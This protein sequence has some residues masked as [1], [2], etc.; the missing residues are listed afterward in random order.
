MEALKNLVSIGIGSI[1]KIISFTLATILIVLGL[2]TLTILGERNVLAQK[3]ETKKENIRTKEAEIA[4]KS[5]EISFMKA[6]MARDKLDA[7]AKD[8]EYNRTMA[9][10]P[11]Y[12]TSI[13]YVPTGDKCADL[14]GIINEARSNKKAQG[15]SL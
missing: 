7:K 5:K 14:N 15:E 4:L 2:Y 9:A 3:V 8:A 11:K 1:W 6:W 12:I 10:K 13:K